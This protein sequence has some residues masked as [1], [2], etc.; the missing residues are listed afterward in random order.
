M[1]KICIAFVI[2]GSINIIKVHRHLTVVKKSF[3]KSSL[4]KV[5]NLDQSYCILA[6]KSF[7]IEDI[8]VHALFILDL[9]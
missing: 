7:S 4:F 8:N 3:K 1:N 2:P 5:E 9:T 6:Q